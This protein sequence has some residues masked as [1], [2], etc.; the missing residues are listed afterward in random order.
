MSYSAAPYIQSRDRI[1]RV[2]L[3]SSNKQVVYPTNY[4]HIMNRQ[5]LDEN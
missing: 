5:K 4:Y 2:W 3:D 1:H